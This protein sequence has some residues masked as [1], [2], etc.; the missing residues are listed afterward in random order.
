[1]TLLTHEQIQAEY[2]RVEKEYND[3]LNKSSCFAVWLAWFL[4]WLHKKR[5]RAIVQKV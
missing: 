3:L 5:Y 2:D 1:M 4:F